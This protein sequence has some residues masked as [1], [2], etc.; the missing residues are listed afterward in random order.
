MQLEFF[1][2]MGA[3]APLTHPKDTPDSSS[4]IAISDNLPIGV[5]FQEKVDHSLSTVKKDEA[6]YSCDLCRRGS[7]KFNLVSFLKVIFLKNSIKSNF[8]SK[9]FY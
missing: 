2:S 4:I 5:D 8:P 9:L 3:S 6:I 1:K 7:A